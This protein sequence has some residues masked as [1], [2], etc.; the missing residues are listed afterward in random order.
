MNDSERY[1]QALESL[2]EAFAY[3]DC[4][5]CGRGIESHVISPDMFGNPHAWCTEGAVNE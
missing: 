1:D 3:E 2:M 4:H 5:E